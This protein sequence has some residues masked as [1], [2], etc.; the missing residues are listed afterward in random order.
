MKKASGSCA[1]LRA[2]FFASVFF[3]SILAA[4]L[5]AACRNEMMIDILGDKSKGDRTG[6][7]ALQAGRFFLDSGLNPTTEVT[8][9]TA[10]AYEVSGQKVLI[11]S[12]DKPAG[13]SVR[14]ILP[15]SNIGIQTNF[16]QDSPFPYGFSVVQDGAVIATA[17]MSPY[18]YEA[19][20]FSMT[21][22]D[23]EG[24]Q[25][26]E[27][28]ILSKNALSAYQDDPGIS[29]SENIRNRNILAA[30]ALWSAIDGQFP[31]DSTAPSVFGWLVKQVAKAVQPAG[32]AVTAATPLGLAGLAID[33]ALLAL[34]AMSALP[35]HAPPPAVLAPP[36]A[37]QNVAVT[38]PS[39]ST[40][41]I[42]WSSSSGATHYYIY[43]S[44]AESAPGSALI[45]LTATSYT[46]TTVSPLTV[47][48]YW[49]SGAST[50][51][52]EG[53]LSSPSPV[54]TLLPAQLLSAP[55][56]RSPPLRRGQQSTIQQMG[57]QP[58][59]RALRIRHRFQ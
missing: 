12:S 38:A 55:R 29:L 43:R 27:Q 11:T 57:L 25:V 30:M 13:S 6:G 47:Y 26:F 10:F 44:T 37:P 59:P 14:F 9:T 32:S 23:G 35:V 48:Y 54:K 46:D 33:E 8:D 5:F 51:F 24:P 15:D 40:T 36:A 22:H 19:Q 56:L 7:T 31:D 49:V 53:A 42:T 28:I 45:D 3:A 39:S 4:A 16:A 17:D 41:Q 21:I 20:R 1:V 18:D 58:L 34:D 52:G 2:V 50:S